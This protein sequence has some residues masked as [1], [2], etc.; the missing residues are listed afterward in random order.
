[1]MLIRV[2]P[3]TNKR[4]R[5]SSKT[6]LVTSDQVMNSLMKPSMRSSLPSIRMDLEPSRNPKWLFSSS[7]SSVD[8]EH[9]ADSDV[10]TSFPQKMLQKNEYDHQAA[11][12]YHTS[13]ELR[14]S[15]FP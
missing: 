11:G 2:E 8:H 6:P 3:S 10:T 14:L 4:P 5:S 12:G 13:H 9:L 15:Q 1:M 7:N